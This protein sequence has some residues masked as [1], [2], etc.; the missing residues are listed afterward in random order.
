MPPTWAFDGGGGS[1][2]QAP[3]QFM[4]TRSGGNNS[5]GTMYANTGKL[6]ALNA[7]FGGVPH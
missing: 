7:S 6:S 4:S 3:L 1:T 2:V 5:A